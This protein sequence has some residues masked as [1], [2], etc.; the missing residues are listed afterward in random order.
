M[1]TP[2]LRKNFPVFVALFVFLGCPK[3]D[4]N[5]DPDPVDDRR[6]VDYVDPLIGAG[7][8]AFGIAAA[9]PGAT[10]PFGLVR[11]GPDTTLESSQMAILHCAGYYYEDTHIEAFSHVQLHGTGVADYG[12]I[13][14]MPT[15]G[16]DASRTEEAGYR[17]AFSHDTEEVAAGYYAVTLDDTQIRVELT[18]TRHAGM[19]RYTF[20]ASDEAVVIMDINHL[21]GDGEITD[22]EIHLD[23]DNGEAQLGLGIYYHTIPRFLGGDGHRARN[24]FREALRLMPDNPEPLVWLSISYRLE[25]R[26]LDARQWLD[27]ALAISP[28]DPFVKN[29]DTRLRAEER[30]QG[31]IP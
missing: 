28:D 5:P 24:H 22:G 14:F 26:L 21:V 18:A 17:S 19:Q 7:G 27:Q 10:T 6:P 4:P 3:V 25:G 31:I 12:N 13:A 9:F 23:P 20:P 11:L 2:S 1:Y 8:L 30:N 29:E 15:L 16:M